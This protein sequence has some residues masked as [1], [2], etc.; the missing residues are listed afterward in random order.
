MS[1]PLITGGIFGLCMALIEVIKYLVKEYKESN[2][3]KKLK[4]IQNTA[5]VLYDLKIVCDSLHNM[6][7][8]KDEDGTPIWYVPRASIKLQK[9]MQDS[10]ESMCHTQETMAGILQRVCEVIDK[11][12]RRQEKQDG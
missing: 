11:I 12:D 9:D 2:T 4:E 5:N 1:D 3:D 10:L 7:D 8:V 6:H